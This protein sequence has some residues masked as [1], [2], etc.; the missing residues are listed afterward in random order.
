MSVG[1]GIDPSDPESIKVELRKAEPRPPCNMWG[2]FKEILTRLESIEARLDILES[3][4]G[5][6]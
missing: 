1:N 3:L 5:I 4:K 6:K 2:F